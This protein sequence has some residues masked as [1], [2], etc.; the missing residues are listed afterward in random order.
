M[1]KAKK[2]KVKKPVIQNSPKTAGK[3]AGQP[4][5]WTVAAIRDAW[6]EYFTE[7]KHTHVPSASLVP[8][9]DPTLL[10]T[11]AGMVQFKPFFAGT[12]EPPYRRAATIQKCLRTTDLESVGK[13]ERHCTFFE[14]LGN[15]SFADYFKKEAIEFAW[16]FSIN[17]LLLNPEKIHVTVYQD[18]DEAVRIWKETADIPDNRITKLGKEHNWWGPAGNSGA[19][20]PCTELYLDRGVERC[21]CADKSTCAPGSECD[22]FMEYWNLVFNEFNQDVSGQL[23]PLPGKGID[24]GAGLERMAA[25]LNGLDSVYDTDEMKNIILRIE[26][27][28]QEIG[29]K[30]RIS[31]ASNAPPFRVMTDHS[32]AATFAIT[33]G[34]IPDN[35]GRGYVVRRIL[36]RGLLFAKELGFNTPV[37]HR[38]VPLIC[39]IYGKYYP[40]ILKK[41]SEIEKR[42]LREEERFLRTLETGLKKWNEYLDE[43]RSA[44]KKI[45]GGYEIFKL[46]DTFGFPP[47]MTVELA[48]KAGLRTDMASYD[49]HMEKQRRSSAAAWKDI[50]LPAQASSWE[51]S[52]FTGYTHHVDHSEIAGIIMED[53]ASNSAAAGDKCAIVLRQTPF[54]PEGGGQVGDTGR[55]HSASGAIFQVRDTRKKDQLIL[56][57]GEALEGGF[58][59]GDRITAEVDSDRR[60]N[61]TFHHSAT[62]LLNGA[63]RETLGDHIQQTGSLVAP[64][65]LRFDFSHSEKIENEIL[66]KVEIKVNRAIRAAAAVKAEL[67]PV[68]KARKTGAVATFGEKYGEEVRVVSMGESGQFSIEF[69]G[70]CHVKNTGEIKYFHILKESSP[71]AGNRRIEAL[72]GGSVV[73]YFEEELQKMSAQIQAFNEKVLSQF[74]GSGQNK[75]LMIQEKLPDPEKILELLGSEGGSTA[76]GDLLTLFKNIIKE[77]DKEINRLQKQETN[78]GVLELLG[79]VEQALESAVK[80]GETTIV[81]RVFVNQEMES[82]RIFGDALKE[83]RRNVAVFLANKSPKGPT[84]LFMA[85]RDAVDAGI[86]CGEFI[87]KAA[88]ILGGGG[89]GRPDMAQAGGKIS[90]NVNEA[91][92]VA[93]AEARDRL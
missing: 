64:D 2:N 5:S 38:L 76:L 58:S 11:T 32:R 84:L 36:R 37:L 43:H 14:M 52:Q 51:V 48:M 16:D 90:E 21:T 74:Q 60:E 47:E 56:H 4:R 25:L 73:A 63:L 3:T 55:I 70:G 81:R 82:L 40:E 49:E 69:C 71:G 22:R 45:F 83:K 54:Y 35:T 9:A 86:H 44:G 79:E 33:D 80:I 19:C 10:F 30:G 78:S 62:H 89:G 87:R 65:Y 88:A 53:S 67:M 50:D 26:E 66:K 12:E 46:Y 6:I 13:T 20:G 28:T 93:E 24:T 72:A 15:F 1:A 77:K 27:L 85:N 17:R 7:K 31:Y 18:D 34:I 23:N 59:T 57:F 75:D 8:A 41:K 68:Q 92:D 91:L 61:L 29:D 39:D 42:I